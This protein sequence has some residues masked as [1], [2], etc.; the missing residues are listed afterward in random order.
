MLIEP[1]S[2]LFYAI[3]ILC[4]ISDVLD[5]YIARKS[6]SVSKSGAFIDSI[7]SISAIEE[8][9]INLIKKDLDKDICGLLLEKTAKKYNKHTT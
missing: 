4:G 9:I 3:Y 5:G 8:L 7:A 6:N 2:V 1:L